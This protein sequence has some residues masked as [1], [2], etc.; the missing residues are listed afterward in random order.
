M[1][2]MSIRLICFF[3]GINILAIGIILNTRSDLGVAAFTSFFYALSK[4]TGISLGASSI[5]LYLTLIVLQ[6]ILLG[7]ISLPVL[8]QIPFSFVFGVLTDFYDCL[9]P[10]T[11]LSLGGKV[12]LLALAIWLTSIGVYLYTNCRLVMTPVEGTVQ[13]IADRWSLRFSLVKNCFDFSMLLLTICLCLALGRPIFGIGIGTVVSALFLGR[14][15][16]IY[17][18]HV[19]LKN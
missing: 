14:I 5:L 19:T 17:E 2:K 6:T 13:T 8:L 10:E 9:I 12:L 3:I 4:I 11:P 7:R 16:G 18:K 15:I 1:K